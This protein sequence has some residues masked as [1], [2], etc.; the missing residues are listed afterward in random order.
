MS[1]LKLVFVIYTLQKGGAERVLSTLG[2]SFSERAYEVVIVC[3]NDAEQGYPLAEGIRVI[4]L[5]KRKYKQNV[6]RR[7]IYGM[8][9]Y[10][11]LLGVL[12]REKP[13]CVISFM[14]SANL[15]TGLSCGLLKIPYIVSERTT[16]DHTINRFNFFFKWMSYFVYSGSKAVVVPAKGIEACLK[17]NGIFN[18]LTNYSIIRN[19]VYVF[20]SKEHLIVHH[21][22]FILGVGR[23]SYEKGFDQLIDAF[24]KLR[25]KNIDLIIVGQGLEKPNL[26]AQINRLNLQD[27]V[28]LA[29]AKDDLQDYYNQAE[30]FVL[31]SRN[32]GYPNALIEA[33]S[34]GCP[35]V[36]VDCEFGPSEIIEDGQ[37]GILVPQ[38]NIPAMTKAMFNVLFDLSLKK[39]LG[40]EARLIGQTNS[41]EVIS[42]KWEALI[43]SPA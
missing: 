10:F 42:D 20:K 38:G 6:F 27:R 36:A 39:K 1:G 18:R 35:C 31:P 23:L 16:P 8:L 40:N 4:P 5:L 15:W 9:T 26:T 2:N 37:N 32:E 7:L 25:I 33:M 21:R 30:L 13:Y 22:K 12:L 28:I 14:T 3:M 43:L 34:S 19:P 17:N 29:G 24:S 11:R 41:L